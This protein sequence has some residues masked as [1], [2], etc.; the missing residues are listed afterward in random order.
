[1]LEQ[2]T[3]NIADA[4]QLDDTAVVT[5]HERLD[6]FSAAALMTE[7]DRLLNAGVVH[8]IVDLSAV[9]VADGDGDYPLLHLLKS[10]QNVDGNVVLV[11]PPGNP[12]RI[13]YEMM[14]MNT[15]FD[16][17]NSLEEALERLALVQ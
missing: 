14:H 2:T 17:V 10:T 9:R 3:Q 11:C 1:M 16:I 6:V 8:F 12:I 15:L 13:F 4:R 7:F 5:V